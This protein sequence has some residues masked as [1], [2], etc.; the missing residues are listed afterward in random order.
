MAWPMLKGFSL[1]KETIVS[2]SGLHHYVVTF[3]FQEIGLTDVLELS[4]AMIGAGFSTTLSD[5]QGHPNELGTNNFGIVSAL[6]LEDIRQ[7]A[8]SI[9]KMLLEKEPEVEVQ[10][11]TQFRKQNES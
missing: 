6:E 10:T 8:L 7:Q 9:G 2:T 3:R 4:S 1:N 5:D 11:F